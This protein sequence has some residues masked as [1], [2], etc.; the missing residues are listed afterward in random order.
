VQDSEVLFGLRVALATRLA[1]GLHTLGSLQAAFSLAVVALV[2]NLLAPR[3]RHQVITAQVNPDTILLRYRNGLWVENFDFT[4][5][6]DVP[7]T[8]FMPDSRTLHL[9]F[10]RT[11]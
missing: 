10:N 4:Q 1:T 8:R 7:A 9:T 3:G 6:R 11:D 2:G 5:E